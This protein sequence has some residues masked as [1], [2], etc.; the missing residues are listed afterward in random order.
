MMAL[1]AKDGQQLGIRVSKETR[2]ALEKAAAAQ[3][4]TMS[5]LVVKA[6]EAWLKEHGWLKEPKK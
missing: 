5:F 1:M 2:L 6:V 3:E 4:R